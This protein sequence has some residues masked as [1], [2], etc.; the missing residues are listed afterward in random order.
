MTEGTNTTVAACEDCG[1]GRERTEAYVCVSCS[2]RQICSSCSNLHLRRADSVVD[3]QNHAPLFCAKHRV[4]C[5][6]YC[7]TCNETACSQ[8]LIASHSKHEFGDLYESAQEAKSKLIDMSANIEE[9]QKKLVNAQMEIDT[10]VAENN[11][12]RD[13]Y[14][15]KLDVFCDMAALTAK[16]L[17]SQAM[18]DGEISDNG[19]ETCLSDQLTPA[20]EATNSCML[21]P[22]HE[23]LASVNETLEADSRAVARAGE[24]SIASLAQYLS[25]HI[26][27]S[28]LT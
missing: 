12:V 5:R 6:V 28:K 17:A 25:S 7:R 23:L 8:C 19:F 24:S 11:S 21:K 20:V 16:D 2:M 4:V 18:P 10:Q 15:K 13:E 27:I 22:A 26:S 1:E 9:A 14:R 3:H